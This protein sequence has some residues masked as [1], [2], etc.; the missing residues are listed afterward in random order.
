MR[1]VVVGVVVMV[2]VLLLVVIAAA[3]VRIQNIIIIFTVWR[4]HLHNQNFFS[5]GAEAQRGPGPPDS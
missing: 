2:V 4:T 1:V 3:A 5:R